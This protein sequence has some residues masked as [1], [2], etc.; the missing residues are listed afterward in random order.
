MGM[1][2]Y[3]VGVEREAFES[4]RSHRAAA[5][6]VLLHPDEPYEG[7]SE[8]ALHA[9]FAAEWSEDEDA[10]EVIGHLV[11]LVR[12]GAV[13]KDKMSLSRYQF[14]PLMELFSDSPVFGCIFGGGEELGEA[15][16]VCNSEELSLAAEGLQ[17]LEIEDE[18]LQV[19]VEWLRELFQAAVANDWVIVRYWS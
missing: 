6:I 17:E 14:T 1:E 5:S 15:E 13:P 2:A 9:F 16:V 10:E 7:E 3:F 11:Y 19:A 12:R 8:E 4:V 18:D